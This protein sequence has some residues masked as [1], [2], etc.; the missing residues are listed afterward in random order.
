MKLLLTLFASLFL[1]PQ[2]DEIYETNLPQT[3]LVELQIKSTSVPVNEFNLFQNNMQQVSVNELR[4]NFDLERL[5]GLDKFVSCTIKSFTVAFE[6]KA[7]QMVA[8]HQF[9]YGIQQNEIKQLAN[10]LSAGTN[11]FIENIV[12]TNQEGKSRKIQSIKV[13]LIP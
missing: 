10:R 3:E 4:Q 7:T 9:E 1:L 6:N 12:Y 5:T 2:I 11:L 13:F 8:V